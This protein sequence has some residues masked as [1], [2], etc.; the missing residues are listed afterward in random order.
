LVLKKADWFFKKPID[1]KNLQLVFSK[2]R[3]ILKIY[4]WFFQKADWF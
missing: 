1:F 2:S 3:L 4:N